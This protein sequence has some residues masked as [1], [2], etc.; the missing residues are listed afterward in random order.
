MKSEADLNAKMEISPEVLQR[1]L[2]QNSKEDTAEDEVDLAELWQGLMKRKWLIVLLSGLVTF[3][4]VVAT[5][6]M[7]P[8]YQSSVSLMPVSSGDASSGLASKY[9]GLASLA[10]ISLPSG[11]GISLTAEA[12]ATLQSKRFLAEYILEKDLKK[13]L[14]Y[15]NWDTEAGAWR[16]EKSWM[17][18]TK[19]SIKNM[20]GFEE[21]QAK[22]SYAGQEQ[23]APGEPS[24]YQV[25]KFFNTS[26]LSVSEDQKSSLTSLNIKWIDPVQSKSWANELVVRVDNELRQKAI[27]EAQATIDYMHEKLP[28]I[29]LQDLRSI[30]LQT[31]EENI[32][33]I[34]FAQVNKEYVFKVIDPAIVAEKASS[35]K[36]GLMVAVGF[37]LGLMLSIFMALI[38]NWRDS[39]RLKEYSAIEKAS[40]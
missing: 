21:E 31:I 39:A 29:K 6:F 3:S 22:V 23:L 26:V 37:V 28:T 19:A 11:G 12:I 16:T 30:A 15:Q 40:D 7:T 10:G 38:L 32:K 18:S 34:T 36:K 8:L 13:Q 2:Q 33:K 35:P 17:S 25:A 9:G 27:S 5:F 1:L 20:L 4:M 24:V 14:F